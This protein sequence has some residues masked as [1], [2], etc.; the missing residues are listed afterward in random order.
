MNSLGE[1]P[2][3]DDQVV[4]VEE[5]EFVGQAVPQGADVLQHDQVR[6]RELAALVAAVKEPRQIRPARAVRVRQQ[7]RNDPF[8]R[9]YFVVELLVVQGTFV[10]VQVADFH[11]DHNRMVAAVG[12]DHSAEYRDGLEIVFSPAALVQ[13]ETH[14]LDVFP[15]R[16][17]I[18]HH[19]RQYLFVQ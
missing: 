12:R 9:V 14:R 7:Q 5:Q 10:L 19:A 4:V 11:F 15:E 8:V 6:C 16:C 13:F 2:H 3:G 1:C 17:A 18:G